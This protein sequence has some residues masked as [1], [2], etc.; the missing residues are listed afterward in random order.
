MYNMYI[1][2]VNFARGR[3]FYI[4][5]RCNIQQWRVIIKIKRLNFSFE[6]LLYKLCDFHIN[7]RK[8]FFFHW[9]LK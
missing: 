5:I 1:T 2:T 6:M 4:F 9:H 8:Y 3:S 7:E